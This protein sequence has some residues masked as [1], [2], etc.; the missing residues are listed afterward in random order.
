MKEDGGK[1]EKGK[2]ITDFLRKPVLDLTSKAIAK[3]SSLPSLVGE[4]S[5]ASS[6]TIITRS[7]SQQKLSAIPQ[8]RSKS[9]VPAEKTGSNN[10]SSS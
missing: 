5:K 7:A 10:N 1:N 9:D 2:K 6:D 4:S 3:A 8:T